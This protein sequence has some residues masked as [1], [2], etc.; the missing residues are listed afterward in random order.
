M[1]SWFV[2]GWALTIGYLPQSSIALPAAIDASPAF[3]QTLE[4]HA[5]LFGH[6]RVW[7][8]LETRDLPQTFTDWLPYQERYRLGLELY[9]GMLAIGVKHECIHP[10]YNGRFFD[11]FGA[12]ETEVYIRIGSKE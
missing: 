1:P 10:V 8:E 9:D 3:E 12:A 11:N 6:A 2:L 5:R 4:L 7:T